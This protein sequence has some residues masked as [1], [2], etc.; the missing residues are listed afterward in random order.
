MEPDSIS[1]QMQQTVL[2]FRE[3]ALTRL[4]QELRQK[5]IRQ[6]EVR[7]TI[8]IPEPTWVERT[9]LAE[10]LG[11]PLPPE[12]ACKVSLK[13][14]DAALQQSGFLCTLP[15]L[16]SA[17]FPEQPLQTRKEQRA[18][19]AANLA[20]FQQRL[21]DLTLHLPSDSLGKRWLLTGNHG[22]GWFVSTQKR[23]LSEDLDFQELFFQRIMIVAT[24]LNQLPA[25]G[26]YERLAIFA[27]HLNGDPHMLDE[28]TEVGKLFLYAL[29]DCVC[30]NIS[31][32]E[33]APTSPPFFPQ[34]RGAVLHLYKTFGLLC[35]GISSFVTVSRL[36]RAFFLDGSP[37]PL[38]DAS[39]GRVLQLPLR[40][41]AEW[42]HCVC[43]G[44]DVYL[45]ENPQVFEEVDAYLAS[46]IQSPTLI[47]TSG[48]LGVAVYDLL[49]R[50]IAYNPAVQ[51][52]YS[53]DFDK[54]GLWIA[55][56]L[57]RRYPHHCHLWRF[58]PQD[59]L[60][61]LHYGGIPA[62]SADL[63]QLAKLPPVFQPLVATIEKQGKWAYQEGIIALLTNS[64]L[65]RLQNG[66]NTD[67]TK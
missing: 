50:I 60:A 11:Q 65:S 21:Q 37:D 6:G 10:L 34:G 25:A 1:N 41:L 20:A 15:S 44:E 57:L 52:H 40:Q 3:A 14:F 35:D 12:T 5:Y 49:D 42:K 43:A 67:T 19:Q 64:L 23:L 48:W 18:Q 16:L 59:Y 2:Y 38:I 45:L 66:D 61:A 24:A 47:C 58:D 54:T 53:G 8:T 17:F 32:A 63:A 27:Q 62:S 22:L 4:L 30:L 7:G 55:D 46:H 29:A 51:F 39:A 28:T 26:H 31:S 56:S 13:A 9:F 33:S 36:K